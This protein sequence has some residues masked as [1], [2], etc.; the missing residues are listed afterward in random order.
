M[1][2]GLR[3]TIFA[4]LLAN[5]AF[6]L[7]SIPQAWPNVWDGDKYKQAACEVIQAP[8][9]WLDG[10]LFAQTSASYGDQKNPRGQKITHLFDAISGVSVYDVS[11][12]KATFTGAYYPTKAYKIWEFND[13]DFAKT[14]VAW[15]TMFSHVN[16]S[17]MKMW[18]QIPYEDDMNP[19]IDFWKIGKQIVAGTESFKNFGYM[20]D[21]P[22]VN[23]FRRFPFKNADNQLSG[24]PY[25]DIHMPI[26]EHIDSDTGLIWNTVIAANVAVSPFSFHQIVFTLDDKGVRTI[27]GVYDF[28]AVDVSKCGNDG[29]YSGLTSGNGIYFPRYMHTVSG[30]QNYLILPMTSLVFRTCQ[31]IKP[32]SYIP[33]NETVFDPFQRNFWFDWD[34]KAPVVFLLFDKRS[35][36]FLKP[37]EHP[38]PQF[39]SHQFTSYE[40]D[41]DQV[42]V[43]IIGFD[44]AAYS[45]FDVDINLKPGDH[46]EWDNHIFRYTLDV[47]ANMA[48]RRLQFSDPAKADFSQINHKFEGKKYRYGYVVQFPTLQGNQIVKI[49]MDTPTGENNKIFKPSGDTSFSEPYFVPKPGGTEEEDGVL[50]TRAF[51]VSIN[52][53]RIYVIDAKSMNKVG[54]ILSPYYTPFGLHERFYTK[55]QLGM[56]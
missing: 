6:A 56:K 20:F 12:K 15:G 21:L 1:H 16:G 55:Q 18:Q 22:E 49:D 26:H 51:D 38:S 19:N 53:T 52:R 33:E 4:I 23:N 47:K 30:S 41:N 39:F 35:K 9:A 45:G 37:I 48:K 44:F 32:F 13:R 43:D 8:P 40:F 24:Q 17:A 50:V 7:N 25:I 5:I 29:S 14:K 27:Q 2:Y 28:S 10:F 11:P 3:V 31:L 34:Q 42:N 36:K 54:E 46:P